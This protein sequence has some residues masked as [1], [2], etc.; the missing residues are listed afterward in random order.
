MYTD[1]CILYNLV[2]FMRM[3]QF[4]STISFVLGKETLCYFVFPYSFHLYFTC[5]SSHNLCTAYP[6]PY[7]PSHH[8]S[9]VLNSSYYSTHISIVTAQANAVYTCQLM[10]AA[11]SLSLRLSLTGDLR[12]RREQLELP[13]MSFSSL[14]GVECGCIV[15]GWLLRQP[16]RLCQRDGH[17]VFPPVEM[18]TVSG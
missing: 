11:F 9:T 3:L 6:C 18:P 12:E 4:Q 14:V 16:A 8:S 5:I 2:I 7:A 1:S 17:A 15:L 10:H 13:C